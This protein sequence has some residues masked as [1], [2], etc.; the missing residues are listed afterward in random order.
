MIDKLNEMILLVSHRK[1]KLEEQ[2]A[3]LK[4]KN[5]DAAYQGISFTYKKG[6]LGKN[7]NTEYMFQ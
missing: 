5:T 3:E 7:T 1:K 2:E 4:R 6:I